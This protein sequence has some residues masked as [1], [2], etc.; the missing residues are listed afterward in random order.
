MV[1]KTCP[2]SSQKRP[3]PVYDECLRDR[4]PV[5]GTPDSYVYPLSEW[6]LETYWTEVTQWRTGTG[7]LGSTRL[8]WGFSQKG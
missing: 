6:L 2:D 8:F 7:G 3:W 1:E 5:P 4:A